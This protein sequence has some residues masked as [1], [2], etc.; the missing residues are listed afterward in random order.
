[1]NIIISIQHVRTTLIN[2]LSWNLFGISPNFVAHG[3]NYFIP[4]SVP[5]RDS[6]HPFQHPRT[7]HIQLLHSLPMSQPRISLPVLQQPSGLIASL[8][9]NWFL[10]HTILPILSSNLIPRSHNTPDT[11]FQFDSSV[12]QYSR[13]SLP[14]WFLGRTIL[15][16][17]SSNLIPRS[18]NTPDTLFQFDSSVTQYS[19]YS[20]PIWFLGHTILPILSSNWIPR[21]H[22]TP[23][24][25]FQFDSSVAQY[26]RYSLPIWFLGHTILPILSSNWIPRS[27]NS[28]D[29]LFQFDHPDCTL[30]RLC[31]GPR[32]YSLAA[33][34]DRRSV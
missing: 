4:Y 1:M 27:H 13:Y 30:D 19:Q 21:S 7:H 25:L 10:G 28:P 29:T 12:A 9:S 18:H 23:D 34:V 33:I 11:F 5:L 2:I 20:L 22:N 32:L 31:L 15:P 24:T 17:L 8:A 6:T 16:I 3:S 26:S 14:I